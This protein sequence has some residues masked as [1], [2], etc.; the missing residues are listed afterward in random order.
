MNEHDT[1]LEY[2]IHTVQVDTASGEEM[3]MADFIVRTIRGIG[4]AVDNILHDQ[5]HAQF[6][7][8]CG[9][10]FISVPATQGREKLPCIGFNAHMDRVQ[11]AFGVK[12]RLTD[13]GRRIVSDGTTVLGADD[14]AGIAIILQMLRTLH[15][16]RIPHGPLQLIF[17]VSEE[18]KLQGAR[19]IDP[20]LIKASMIYSFD[21]DRPEQIFTHTC[22][23]NKYRIIVKGK[24]AHAGVHPEQGISAPLIMARA[25]EALS[26]DGCFGRYENRDQHVAS[27]NFNVEGFQPVGTNSVQA[28][29]VIG[30]ETR[31]FDDQTLKRMDRAIKREFDK[32]AISVMGFNPDDGTYSLRGAVEITCDCAY[33]F[34]AV[35]ANSDVVRRATKSIANCGLSAEVMP[36]VMGG[37]D[38]CWLNKYAPTIALGMGAYKYH[39]VG[40]YL[41]VAE[42][43]QACRIAVAL[44]VL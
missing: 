24:N 43:L 21:G 35:P 7:G 15:D 33:D 13:D 29:I 2:F 32:A 11:P 28:E 44:A 27:S 31:S 12:P 16:L 30:G 34:L 9:N 3:A 10:L 17:T 26:Q 8:N 41:D 42:Y 38:A 18:T 19:H 22:S 39:T 40:E 1:A 5:A 37:L 25:L 4:I 6:G 14:G 20:S 36:P 23:S